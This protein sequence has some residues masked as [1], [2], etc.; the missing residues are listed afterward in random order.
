MIVETFLRNT[1]CNSR[2]FIQKW[3]I[4][5]D[6]TVIGLLGAITR[7]LKEIQAKQRFVFSVQCA[8]CADALNQCPFML[9]KEFVN[10]IKDLPKCLYIDGFKGYLVF[11][12]RSDSL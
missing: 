11:I 9:V 4:D 6:V 1:G 2:L 5:E 8:Y 3:D 12:S 7:K 10:P